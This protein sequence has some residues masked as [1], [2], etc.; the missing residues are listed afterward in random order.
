[1]PRPIR[2][3]SAGYLQHVVCRGNDNQ[4]VFDEPSDYSAYLSLLNDFRKVFPVKIYNYSLMKNHIHL[5]IEPLEEGALSKFMEMVTKDYAK[6]FNQAHDRT[7]HL[8]QGRYKS[9]IVQP[10]KYYFM[11]SRYM[12]LLP[13]RSGEAKTPEKYPWTGF[14]HLAYGEKKTCHV[15]EHELYSAMGKNSAERQFAYKVLVMNYQGDEVDFLERKAGV[16]GDRTFKAELK[17]FMRS[18]TEE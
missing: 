1:M 9:F 4:S 14:G 11:C 2:V 12:D 3:Q 17:P 16:L 10:Q 7:G 13:V 18:G 5:L 15:D 8:F 6:Y